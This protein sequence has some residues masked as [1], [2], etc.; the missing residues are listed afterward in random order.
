MTVLKVLLF[1]AGAILPGISSGVICVIFGIYEKILNSIL[2]FLKKPKENFKFLLPFIIGVFIGVFVFGNLLNYLLYSYPI[3]T[4]SIFIGLI[5]GT[6]PSLI[7]NINSKDK[8][9]WHYLLFL[10]FALIIGISTVFLENFFLI[11]ST[12]NFSYLYLI[13][14]GFFM[15]VGVVV[16][17]VSST[18]ILMLLGVYTTYIYSISSIY[19][20]VLIP[21][22]IGLII[23][24]II[25]MYITKF[26]LNNFY[27]AT[28]FIIIGFTLG[29][30]GVIYPSINSVLDFA[31]SILCILLGFCISK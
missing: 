2:Y 23:G 24:G 18:I 5:L 11:T 7:R 16:P 28:M 3:Q 27:G 10:I 15:S 31:I 6:I 20:P 21:M 30:I 4:K 25:W 8:F 14:S 19:L 12:S 29:S 22:G 9:K 26:L 1:G 17:G 13:I